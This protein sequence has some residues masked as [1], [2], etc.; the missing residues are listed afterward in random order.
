MI[1]EEKDF[2]GPIVNLAIV[3]GLVEKNPFFKESFEKGK[4][5]QYASFTLKIPKN[6]RDDFDNIRIRAYGMD[7]I[8]VNDN[9][10]EGMELEIRGALRRYSYTSDEGLKLWGTCI[11]ADEITVTNAE[12]PQLNEEPYVPIVFPKWME[13]EMD[14]IFK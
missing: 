11:I 2:S 6:L 9:V 7:A 5:Q 3:S 8:Y 4:R 14:E 13:A 10:F 12:R 1:D